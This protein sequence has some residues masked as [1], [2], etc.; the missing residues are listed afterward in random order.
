M[1][2]GENNGYRRNSEFCVD[3]DGDSSAVIR[4]TDKVSGKNFYVDIGAIARKGFVDGV[5]DNFINKVMKTLG[6]GGADIH[7][8]SFSYCFKSFKDLDLVFVVGFLHRFYGK[9][10]IFHDLPPEYFSAKAVDFNF[11]GPLVKGGCHLR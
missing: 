5:V 3:T 7:T 9:R 6:A 10:S 1:K 8:G 2:N 4:Y 11:L